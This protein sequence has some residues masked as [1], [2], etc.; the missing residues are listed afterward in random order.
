MAPRQARV[1]GRRASLSLDALRRR[2][3]DGCAGWIEG[4]GCGREDA[5]RPGRARACRC[6]RATETN[7]RG[8]RRR[9]GREKDDID[10]TES[11]ARDVHRRECMSRGR[12]HVRKGRA[13]QRCIGTRRKS[14]SG[15]LRPRVDLL[16]VEIPRFHAAI[17]AT[18]N[19]RPL[20]PI[21]GDSFNHCSFIC[22]Q[23]QSER[24]LDKQQSRNNGTWSVD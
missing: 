12:A 8:R 5:A 14:W 24:W 4:E 22:S 2:G 11:A 7:G 6:A 13:A 9:P 3:R 19:N 10:H 15:L 23:A 20:Q 18:R 21:W 1:L 17:P 16:I